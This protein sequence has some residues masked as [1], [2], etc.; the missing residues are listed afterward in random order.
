MVV[1]TGEAC[2]VSFQGYS[3]ED[4]GAVAA[5]AHEHGHGCLHELQHEQEHKTSVAIVSMDALGIAASSLCIVHCAAMPFV[6]GLL[7]LIGLQ[8]LSGHTAHM[9]LAFF[10]FTFALSAV[11]PGYL[12]HRHSGVLAAM[13]L[14]L[15]LVLLATFG[16]PWI[17]TEQAELP[18]I[19]LGNIILVATHWR[20]RALS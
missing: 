7:P 17:I 2:K 12:K 16:N 20:N 5:M 1:P 15:S 9:C 18:L 11:V 19:S 14:G 10:V 6:V 13:L 3:S 8:F 4:A